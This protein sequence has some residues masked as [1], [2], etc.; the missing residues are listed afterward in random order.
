[1]NRQLT[2]KRSISCRGVGLQS[3]APVE[4][5]LLPASA[6]T[7][8]TFRRVD[9]A[10]G[11]AIRVAPENLLPGSIGLRFS[12]G[13]AVVAGTEHL[14]AALFGLGIDN[15]VID[16][17]AGEVPLMDG[18][19]VRF[20]DLIHQGGIQDLRVARRR[21]MIRSPLTLREGESQLSFYP[22]E[23]LR[24]S[25]ETAFDHPLLRRQS[26]SL[27]VTEE[28]FARDIAPARTFG[29]WKEV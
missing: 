27:G 18:C 8:L 14:L 5:T 23:M 19:A 29:Y 22:A 10:G 16:L 12:T 25:C 26:F 6:N 13:T 9:L 24:I 17:T 3:G 7:G 21:L 28:S 15:A 1:M 11:P 4:M 20:V 2:L